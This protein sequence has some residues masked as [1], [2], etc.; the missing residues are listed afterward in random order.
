M[1]RN[2]LLFIILALATACGPS[3]QVK[4]FE[5]SK[6]LP[7]IDAVV[8]LYPDMYFRGMETYQVYE[9]WT[10]LALLMVQE[11]GLTVIGPDEYRIMVDGVIT[12]MVQETDLVSLLKK[13]G[14]K[15]ENTLALKLT[16]TESWQQVQRALTKKDD[17]RKSSA[18]FE[19]KMEFS[20]DV[21][22]VATNSPVL[23]M[24]KIVEETILALPSEYDSRP[25]ITAFANANFQVLLQM[26]KEDLG[27]RTKG[28]RANIPLYQPGQDLIDFKI[29]SLPDLRAKFEQ[30]DDMEKDAFV[31]ARIGYRHGELER[32]IRRTLQRGGPG[33]LVGS[34]DECTGLK[35]GDWVIAIIGEETI[36]LHRFWLFYDG[37]RRLKQSI[38]Y[39][40]L[41]EGTESEVTD[42]CM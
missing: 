35:P 24:S 22:H 11:L 2:L 41:R 33:L 10:D 34:A 21:Y 9:K 26:F 15:P 5:A 12:S 4:K 20:M 31:Q 39:K 28:A 42:A 16:L 29:Q 37:A 36:R 25:E 27:I 40:V 17:V 38:V 13:R 1:K 6:K 14:L 30:L 8:I 32:G 3:L 7:R 18:E 19:S 23:S